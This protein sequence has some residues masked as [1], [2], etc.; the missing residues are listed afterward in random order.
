MGRWVKYFTD[1]SVEIGEDKDIEKKKAS[2]TKGRLNSIWKV[3]FSN[4]DFTSRA[5]LKSKISTNWYQ[6]DR[7]ELDISTGISIRKFRVAQ[8]ELTNDFVDSFVKYNVDSATF[9][10]IKDST[11]TPKIFKILD[12]HIGAWLSLI[13]FE[14]IGSLNLKLCQKGHY[15]GENII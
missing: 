2:W 11:N 4:Q 5:F 12:S 1:G 14:D 9:S 10:I 13:Y 6:F 15:A 8:L 7:F 3:G